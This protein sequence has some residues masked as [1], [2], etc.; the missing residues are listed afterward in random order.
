MAIY[1]EPVVA[2]FWQ[3]ARTSSGSYVDPWGPLDCTTH[4][5]ARAIMRNYQGVK[6]AGISGQWPPTGGYI[7]S[8]TTNPDGTLDRTGGTNHSQMKQVLS[9]YYGMALDVQNGM[10]WNDFLT[11]VNSGRGAMISVLYKTIASSAFSGQSNFYGN[12]EMF[13]ES[14]TATTLRIIDP[15]ADGRS[16]GIYHGPGDYPMELIKVAA[17][18][19]VLNATTGQTLGYGRVYAAF[20]QVTGSQPTTGGDP[21]LKR[22]AEGWVTNSATVPYYDSPGGTQLGSFPNGLALTSIGETMDGVWR[23]IAISGTGGIDPRWVY[24]NRQDLTPMVPGGDVAFDTAVQNLLWARKA[25]SATD[26]TDAVAA[27]RAAGIAAAA[28]SAAKTI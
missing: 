21:M 28:A 19:L 22:K 11:Q 26:C 1:R 23:L 6:P 25:P 13:C 3:L 27:A 4:S 9:S 5:A 7:R 17:G 24:M 20:T 12:H 2:D 15:L 10:L 14:A 16:A 8:V 18:N